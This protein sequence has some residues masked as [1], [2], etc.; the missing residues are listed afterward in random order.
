[1][2]ELLSPCSL[3]NKLIVEAYKKEALRSKEVN[4][5]AFVDQRLNLKGLKILVSSFLNNGQLFVEAGSTAFIK[6]DLLH[7]QQWAQKPYECDSINGQF[8]IVDVNN[9]EFIQPPEKQ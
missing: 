1:M 6:E 8:L 3:N 7:T 5:F 4:G 2:K 9:V